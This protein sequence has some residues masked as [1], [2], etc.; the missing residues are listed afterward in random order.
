MSIPNK[1][2]ISTAQIICL[3]YDSSLALSSKSIVIHVPDKSLAW[4]KSSDFRMLAQ[5]SQFVT[6][7]VSTVKS[8]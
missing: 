2:Y 8:I 1:S 3:L 6:W 4:Q 7:C 5:S